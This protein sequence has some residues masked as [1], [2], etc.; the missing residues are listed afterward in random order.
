MVGENRVMFEKII[1][2][3]KQLFG[4]LKT[5]NKVSHQDNVQSEPVLQE[6]QPHLVYSNELIPQLK[7]EHQQ[8]IAMY[9][10]IQDLFEHQHYHKVVEH[11]SRFKEE[12]SLHLMQENVKFYA[13]LE[14][15][16]TQ[17]T[18]EYE[19]IKTYRKDMNQIAH[20]VVKFLKKWTAQM[21]LNS[22]TSD[23]F[24]QEYK[25]IGGALVQRITDEEQ[26]LYTLYHPV[27]V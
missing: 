24:F 27:S 6:S 1:T 16:L 12:F 19:T 18:D 2:F 3:F 13:Y 21:S 10:G 14:D 17:D 7:A 26:Y 22:S 20:V 8:L 23:E 15:H 25:N 5:Q 4:M 11:L 9:V